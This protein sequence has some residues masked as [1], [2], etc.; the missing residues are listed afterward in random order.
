MGHARDYG[1]Y[2]KTTWDIGCFRENNWMKLIE[3]TE[4]IQPL[5]LIVHSDIMTNRG[6][7]VMGTTATCWWT[8]AASSLKEGMQMK[9]SGCIGSTEDKTSF[10][11]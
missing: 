11:V 4:W 3:K 1:I 8:H 6:I 7:S 2:I 9:I 10:G 5:R